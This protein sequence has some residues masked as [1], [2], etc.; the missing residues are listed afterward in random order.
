M[1]ALVAAV[2]TPAF[3]LPG[4]NQP[5]ETDPVQLVWAC[6]ETV[7]AMKIAIIASNL[8]ETNLQPRAPE[9]APRRDPMDDSRCGSR[10]ISAPNRWAMPTIKK[11][12]SPN[13]GRH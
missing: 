7:I 5:L 8:D 4:L 12:G 11:T 3:Q 1:F 6:V 13:T 9:A 2:G 10:P